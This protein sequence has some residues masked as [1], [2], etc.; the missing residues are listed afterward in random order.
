MLTTG[1]CSI[2]DKNGSLALEYVPEDDKETR[3]AF[4]RHQVQREILPADIARGMRFFD[5]TENL[6]GLIRR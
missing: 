5:R 2:R 3:N 6:S 1:T 4:R